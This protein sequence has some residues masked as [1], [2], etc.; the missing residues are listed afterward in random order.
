MKAGRLFERTLSR[1]GFLGAAGAAG[2]GLLASSALPSAAGLSLSPQVASAAGEGAFNWLT[3]GDH[4][5]PEQIEQAVSEYGIKANPSLFSDNS[6]AFLKVQ[7]VGGKQIDLVSADALWVPK[8]YEEGLIE[9]FDLWSLDSARG[10]FD[11]ALDV[12]FWKTEDGLDL[13]FPWAWSP[14]IIAYNPEYVTPEP[15]SWEVLWDPKYKGKVI[16]PQ[17]PFDVMAMMGTALEVA[18]PFNMTAE[19]L[20]SAKQLLIDLMPSMLTFT[21]QEVDNT[22]LLADESAWLA[23]VNLGMEESVR[24]AGGP[25]IKTFAPKEG[26]IGYMDGEMIV[27]D[28]ENKDAAMNWLDKMETGKWLAQ[29]FLVNPRPLFNRE[30]YHELE[31][32]GYGDL[33][34]RYLFDKPEIALS[35]TLKGPAEDMGAV[36]EAFNEALATGG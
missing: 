28:A 10:L 3:W 6:E 21:E 35:M 18:E 20:A 23:L 22:K 34:R 4:Y 7:Q 15:D 17:Q 25:E 14:V 30:A 27:K 13:A 33:A 32:M 26:A 16:L 24:D 9:P 2:A 36:I 29:N 5:L 19:E 11:V 1:R 12:P 31:K 8:F